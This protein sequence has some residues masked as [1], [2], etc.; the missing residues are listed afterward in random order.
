MSQRPLYALTDMPSYCLIGTDGGLAEFL[1]VQE[2][3]ARILPATIDLD[4]GGTSQHH[5]FLSLPGRLNLLW[6]GMQSG[7]VSPKR[8]LQL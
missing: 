2:A 1:V 8:H 6:A 5:A 4:V 7:V 3:N